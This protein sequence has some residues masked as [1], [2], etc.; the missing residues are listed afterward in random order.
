MAAGRASADEPAVRPSVRDA[1]SGI[2]SSWFLRS[3]RVSFQTVQLGKTAIE[4]GLAIA[5]TTKG[6]PTELRVQD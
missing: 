2:P 3:D 6:L 4:K 5:L 1:L